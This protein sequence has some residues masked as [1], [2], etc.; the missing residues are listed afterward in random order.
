[1]GGLD[2]LYVGGG[3]PTVMDNSHLLSI[4][5]AARN[6]HGIKDGAEVTVEMDPG[7][8]SYGD[9]RALKGVGVNRV[10]LGVQSFDDIVLET[11]GR[12]HRLSDVL[13]AV[14]VVKRVGGVDMSLDLISAAPGVGLQQWLGTVQRAVDVDPE[15]M[16]V[17]DLQLEDGTVYGRR[18][19]R[20]GGEGEDGEEKGRRDK[21]GCMPD[22][23][24][25]GEAA[26]MYRMTCSSL[27]REGYEHYETSS[28]AKPGKRGRHN[29][30]YWRLGGEWLAAG[31]GATSCVGGRRF[32]RPGR[33]KEYMEWVERGGWGESEEGDHE[34]EVLIDF[35]TTGFRT[36]EG[37]DLEILRAEFGGASVE[38]ILRGAEVA[39]KSGM[40]VVEGT[41]LSLTDPE[42]FLFSDYITRQIMYELN[43]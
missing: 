23:P 20:E 13:S 8:F 2:T 9:L 4:I 27:G 28:F 34:R 6:H 17:Y 14:E 37:V 35:L 12:V 42:G 19:D 43:Q 40:A 29:S 7:T 38:A 10:S 33:Y 11:M 22:L 1:M 5:S 36:M 26:E 25:P 18:Y 31:M 3:T 16:S 15:H 21:K 39:V 41:R 32:A 24:S 30:N